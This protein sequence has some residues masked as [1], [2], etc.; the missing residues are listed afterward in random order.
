MIYMAADHELKRSL[1][2]IALGPKVTTI[3]VLAGIDNI[4]I[5]PVLL[6]KDGIPHVPTGTG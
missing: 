1:A 6:P 5:E 2:V 4:L 3:K